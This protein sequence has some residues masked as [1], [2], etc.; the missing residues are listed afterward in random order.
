MNLFIH[1]V[2]TIC[3]LISNFLETYNLNNANN[4]FKTEASLQNIAKFQSLS[5]ESV[6]QQ[7][8]LQESLND[9]SRRPLL[10]QLFQ[11]SQAPQDQTSRTGNGLLNIDSNRPASFLNSD[12]QVSQASSSLNPHDQFV[13]KI[14]NDDE[15]PFTNPLKT[16][17]QSLLGSLPTLSK[18]P[19]ENDRINTQS[20]NS[21]KL[22]ETI[23]PSPSHIQTSY[24][25]PSKI[26]NEREQNNLSEELSQEEFVDEN[27][28]EDLEASYTYNNDSTF[29]D[30]P[31]HEYKPTTSKNPLLENSYNET[32]QY[33]PETKNNQFDI[34][35]KSS[36]DLDKI[37]TNS[38][39]Q[40]FDNTYDNYE[41]DHV[42][43]NQAF[44]LKDKED[45]SDLGISKNEYDDNLE[46]LD[47][48]E[49]DLNLDENWVN[50]D[51]LEES[52]SFQNTGKSGKFTVE[53][54]SVSEDESFDEMIDLEYNY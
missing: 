25:Y 41:D 20:Y 6:A 24:T 15:T 31:S 3:W 21:F 50:E 14:A 53:D 37:G 46:N 23:S 17:K 10:W 7:L 9:S 49:D 19:A 39:D 13:Q 47:Y 33:K 32:N 16:Q 38:L 40:D 27:V 26:V 52:S 8:G 54:N 44:E 29:D 28:E 42:S 34:S 4:V 43:S 2:I 12:K 1:T 45:D 22:P 35:D 48:L 18:N 36:D 5:E 30:E 11:A 51:D